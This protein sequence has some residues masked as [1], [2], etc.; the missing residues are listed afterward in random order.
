MCVAL[1]LCGTAGA[2]AGAAF[3]GAIPEN[4][5]TYR[6][7]TESGATV[8][9]GLWSA[10]AWYTDAPEALPAGRA[11]VQYFPDT[12][13][14]GRT[15]L[16][17][18]SRTA[19]LTP[20]A[21]PMRRKRLE[22]GWTAA[23]F[24]FVSTAAGQ[25]PV[26]KVDIELAKQA[27]AQAEKVEQLSAPENLKIAAPGVAHVAAGGEVATKPAW[28]GYIG[29][30]I[31]ILVTLVLGAVIVKVLLLGGNDETWERVG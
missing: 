4:V 12:P 5:P 3:F 29:H 8:S 26:R 24:T 19:E 1:L 25:I 11:G 17:R 16:Q 7:S 15:E 23:G 28:Q 21:P 9:A 14:D 20:E 30:A 13:W 31:V 18:L 10:G 2:Q 22:D 27:A 6:L